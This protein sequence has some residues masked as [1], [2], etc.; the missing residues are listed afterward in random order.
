MNGWPVGQRSLLVLKVVPCGHRAGLGVGGAGGG[1]GGRAGGAG[2]GGGAGGGAQ[3]TRA[4]AQT[5]RQ[6]PS[7]GRGGATVRVVRAD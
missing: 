3:R 2:R 4:R 5:T 7:A 1:G 6:G